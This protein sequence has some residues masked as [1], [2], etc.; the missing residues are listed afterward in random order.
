MSNKQAI[1]AIKFIGSGLA[2]GALGS[3][4]GGAA[5]FAVG[6]ILQ[7]VGL[8]APADAAQQAAL[9]EINSSI[10]QLTNEVKK[11]QVI[12]TN[13]D[14]NLKKLVDNTL[15]T[16]WVNQDNLLVP[17][18][19][20]VVTDYQNLE[21]YTTPTSTG[22][23]PKVSHASL[24]AL[25]ERAYLKTD[26][27]DDAINMINKG[28]IGSAGG[29]NSVLKLFADLL[30]NKIDNE[31]LRGGNPVKMMPSAEL[32]NII[33]T[34]IQYYIYISAHQMQAIQI[35]I[36]SRCYKGDDNSTLMSEWNQFNLKME[37][38]EDIFIEQVFRLYRYWSLSSLSPRLNKPLVDDNDLLAMS[39]FYA[40]STN[41]DNIHDWYVNNYD[42]VLNADEKDFLLE[43]E[44]LVYALR[45]NVPGKFR[46][47]IHAIL[48]N[49]RF[50]DSSKPLPLP[51]GLKNS[52]STGKYKTYI[53]NVT[54]GSANKFPPI[55]AIRE[56]HDVDSSGH[57]WL[58]N[59]NSNWPTYE[60][61]SSPGPYTFQSTEDLKLESVVDESNQLGVIRFV[62]YTST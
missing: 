42:K 26:T 24:D 28:I 40:D 57:Y 37:Q 18:L 53:G 21:A 55:N 2:Q 45:P 51:I 38:Q 49:W 12:L 32:T 15:Y 3:L 23:L 4:G 8:G 60:G 62:P 61:Y 11:I 31:T 22:Q 59:V 56:V 39:G 52:K 16:N 27:D 43:A 14:A 17:Y 30:I 10:K 41:S 25:A 47:V 54:I 46:I 34:F 33:E 48:G 9:S 35:I 58:A 7:A 36:A 13:V 5:D 1:Q 20:R 50:V 29:G 19:A 6:G 44:E